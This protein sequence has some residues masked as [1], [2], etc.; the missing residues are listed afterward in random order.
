M[1]PGLT[2]PFRR[3]P[4]LP[5]GVL[6]RRLCHATL[7]GCFTGIVGGLVLAGFAASLFVVAVSAI[8]FLIACALLAAAFYFLANSCRDIIDP[9]YL[10]FYADRTFIRPLGLIAKMRIRRFDSEEVTGDGIT[11]GYRLTVDLVPET[12][13]EKAK[14]ARQNLPGGVL[15]RRISFPNIACTEDPAEIARVLRS[16]RAAGK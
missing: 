4:R 3:R 6:P 2:N 16:L 15:R 7:P 5:E 1:T 14:A 10:A 11:N 13:A 9:V 12:A 8:S